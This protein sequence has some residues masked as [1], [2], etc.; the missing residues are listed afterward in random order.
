MI[1]FVTVGLLALAVTACLVVLIRRAVDR[2]WAVRAE[3]ARVDME[4]RRAERQLHG[5][6]SRAFSSMLEAT[7]GHPAKGDK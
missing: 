5:L 4:V 7:R 1:W 6:A 3:R 2:R